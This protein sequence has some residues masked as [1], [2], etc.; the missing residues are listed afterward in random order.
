MAEVPVDPI[1]QRIA[2]RE[3]RVSGLEKQV[4]ILTEI[5]YI[6]GFE[7][8]AA[9]VPIIESLEGHPVKLAFSWGKNAT[10]MSSKYIDGLRRETPNGNRQ[11]VDKFLAEHGFDASP[12]VVT[13]IGKFAGVQ[14]QIEE[15]DKDYVNLDPDADEKDIQANFVITQDKDL[16][17]I[18]RP[19]DCP[20]VIIYAKDRDGN[21]LVVIDHSGREALNAGMSRQGAWYLEENYGVDLSKATAAILPGMARKN[22]FITDDPERWGNSILERNWGEYIDERVDDASR[23][24]E[25]NIERNDAGIQKRH[26]DMTKAVIMQLIQAGFDPKNVQAIDVDSFQAAIDEESFSHRYTTDYGGK[27]PGRFLVAVKLKDQVSEMPIPQS[28]L[29]AA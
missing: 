29:K 10:N 6:P 4:S 11:N 12:N 28:F 25:L 1:E 5:P 27:R 22:Y 15:V 9:Y 20:I 17:L 21:P 8:R 13:V 2:Q 7:Q 23:D 19:A 14:Q 18:I 26:V 24:K 3:A 16:T